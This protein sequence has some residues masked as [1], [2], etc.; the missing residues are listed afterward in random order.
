MVTHA[1]AP[2]F[3][4]SSYLNSK[5]K[6]HPFF[7]YEKIE[8]SEYSNHETTLKIR[9]IIDDLLQRMKCSRENIKICI[10]KDDDISA[11]FEMINVNENVLKNKQYYINHF[12]I[13]HELIHILDCHAERKL[14][15]KNLSMISSTIIAT[16][17]FCYSIPVAFSFMSSLCIPFFLQ[18][19][20]LY[21]YGCHIEYQADM[22]ALQYLNNKEILVGIKM[23]SRKIRKMDKI[24]QSS[25]FWE[26]IVGYKE[27][28]LNT[29]P[30]LF[31]RRI[32]LEN[33]LADRK[34]S[35][36]ILA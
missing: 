28:M 30:S 23:F 26:K 20:C 11:G 35:E 18:K 4:L 14:Q 17:C 2:V 27:M 8:N 19:S 25:T 9:T 7:E 6:N 29:H 24:I 16:F 13:G 5:I 21:L 32:L 33:E 36:K 3:Y 34:K 10:G 12:V 15:I 1:I 31:S 22:K